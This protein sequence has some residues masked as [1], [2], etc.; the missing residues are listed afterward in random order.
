LTRD[1]G[2]E[3]RQWPYDA[4]LVGEARQRLDAVVDALDDIHDVNDHGI[5]TLMDAHRWVARR[6]MPRAGTRAISRGSNTSSSTTSRNGR[7]ATSSTGSRSGSHRARIG[8]AWRGAD[9]M[10]AALARAGVDIR[11]EAMGVTWEDAEAAMR[12]LGTFVRE[13]GLWHSIADERAVDDA[14]V[15][16]VR[17]RVTAAY[18][19]WLAAT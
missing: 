1:L 10:V 6:S 17:A 3:E 7:D 14:I 4:G 9:E 15:A 18:G 19:P 16:E 2:K 8:H 12:T 5:R 11:P 13:A